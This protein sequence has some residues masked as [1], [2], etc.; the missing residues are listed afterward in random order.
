VLREPPA[1]I[2]EVTQRADVGWR[3]HAAWFPK[4]RP[5]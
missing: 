5:G 3:T 4:R 2:D 1:E